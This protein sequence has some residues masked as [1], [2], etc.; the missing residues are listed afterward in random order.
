[1]RLPSLVAWCLLRRGLWLWLM[2]RLG[3]TAAVLFSAAIRAAVAVGFVEVRCL[4]TIRALVERP[5]GSATVVA[6]VASARSHR[7]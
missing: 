3:L 2:V 1:M 5:D 4:A 6:S 7:A